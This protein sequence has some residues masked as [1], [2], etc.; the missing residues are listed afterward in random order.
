MTISRREMIVAMGMTAAA[1]LA[2]GAL[3]RGGAQAAT[4]SPRLPLD[5]F[6]KSDT[7]LASLRRGVREMQKRKPSDPLSWFFQAAIHG[8]TPEAF[9]SAAAGDP[10]VT[11]QMLTKYW[12]KCPHNGEH[13][14]N[15]LP[16]HRGYTYHFERILRMHTGDDTFSL[17]Y[18]NYH[19]RENRRFPREFGI[20]HLDG[21][22][23]NNAVENLNPLY[24]ESRDYYVAT[25]E[26]WTKPQGGFEPLFD[27][28]DFAVDITLPMASPVFFGLTDQEGLG[29]GLSDSSPSTRGLLESY[30]HDQIHRAVGGIVITPDGKDHAGAMAQPPTAGFDPIFPVHHANIDR[31]WAE[32]SCMPGKDWGATPDK[33]W[34]DERPWIF[35]DVDGS[36][37]NE[38]RKKYFDH[39]ALGVRFKDEDMSCKPLQ[40]PDHIM[41]DEP[42]TSALRATRFT[43]AVRSAQTLST[44]RTDFTAASVVQRSVIRVPDTAKRL[45]RRPAADLKT[46]LRNNSKLF[47]TVTAEKRIFLR[48]RELDLTSL[49]GTG[50]DVHLTDNPQGELTRASASFVG[51]VALFRHQAPPPG[52]PAAHAGHAAPPAGR[53]ARAAAL[54]QAEEDRHQIF[55]VTRAVTAVGDANLSNLSVVLVPYSLVSSPNREVV[56]LGTNVLKVGGIEFFMR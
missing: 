13:S 1:G 53:K 49:H 22:T 36:E 33:S 20:L 12:N 34:F 41:R 4:P 27:L 51:S 39:R 9:N 5:E 37:V 14:A 43:A 21:N 50:F 11:G 23:G 46:K 15:F 28:S 8:V 26:H 31:L 18:W 47:A 2:G 19:K 38:P 56:P 40:L 25:Y 7:L 45:L 17:P 10:A 44:S 42:E 54:R 32:W 29:G 48:L 24:L 30:P 55:D 35:F 3:A 6:V 52:Q 16:W